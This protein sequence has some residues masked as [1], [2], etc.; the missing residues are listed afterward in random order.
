MAKRERIT[1]DKQVRAFKAEEA[2]YEHAV[3][4]GMGLRLR[5][6]PTGRKVWRYRY[7]NRTTGALEV[8]TLG[9]YPRMGLA[10][11]RAEVERQRAI[12]NEHGSA[13]DY[14]KAERTEK[15]RALAAKVVTDERAGYTVEKMV[16]QY[17]DEASVGLKSWHEVDRALRKYVVAEIG[18]TPA[19]EVTRK[20]V[21]AL[22]DKLSKRG[23]RVQANR[24][25][26]YF[27][28]CCN[29]A[30]GKDKLSANPCA[31]IE[32]HAEQAKERYLSDAEIA[33]FLTNLPDSGIDDTIADVY[34]MILLTGVRPGEAAGIALADIDSDAGAIRLPD[35]KAGRPH[36]VPLSTEARAIIDRRKSEEAKWLFPMASDPKK[37]IRPDALPEPLREALQGLGIMRTTPHDLRRT[38]GTGLARLGAPRLL[39]SLA[40][41]HAVQ[42]VTSVYDRHGYE[43]ELRQ[44]FDAWGKHVDGL[45][46]A[47]QKK[48]QRAVRAA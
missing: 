35:T 7:R 12:A 24:V 2:V 23:K 16:G 30:I 20:D 17:L 29:W 47:A 19:H 13:R 5:V 32:R 26:A 41:N 34:R 38:F 21:I 10:E 11:A 31:M 39:L 15:H 3:K 4:D 9:E 18:A 28:R 1:T 8:V 44:W 45:V 40:L 14:H 25:L 43:K 36:V 27:R 42:G 46:K 37:H 6:S 33:R 22:L 48:A